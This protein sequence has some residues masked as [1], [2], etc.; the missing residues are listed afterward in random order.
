MPN[1][2]MQGIAAL[3]AQQ[4]RNGDT[5]LMHV[6]PEEIDALAR[7]GAIS[8]NPITKLPEAFKLKDLVPFIGNAFLGPAGS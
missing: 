4:G 6:A 5:M 1:S 7:M 2:N 3:I 8:E